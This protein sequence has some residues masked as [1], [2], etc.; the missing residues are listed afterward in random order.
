MTSFTIIIFII[1]ISHIY[2]DDY[3]KSFVNMQVSSEN[4][5][6]H[7]KKL[8]AN[9]KNR[10]TVVQVKIGNITVYADTTIMKYPQ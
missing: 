7:Y 4:Q 10:L 1:I 2:S 3:N 6:K 5:D 9:I 8:H